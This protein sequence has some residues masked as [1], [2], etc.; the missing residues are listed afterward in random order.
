LSVPENR[1]QLTA[2]FFRDEFACQCGCGFDAISLLMV[3]RLQQVREAI[4]IPIKITSGCRCA[5]HNKAIGGVEDSGHLNGFA[6]DIPCTDP[7]KRK[8]LV[9]ALLTEVTIPTEN[10]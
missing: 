4:N 8:T 2:N 9:Q 5:T 1:E 3:D 10:I 6:V 7:F